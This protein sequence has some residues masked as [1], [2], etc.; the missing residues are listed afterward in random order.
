LKGQEAIAEELGHAFDTSGYRGFLKTYARIVEAE[1]YYYREARAYAMLREKDAAFAALEKALNTRTGFRN[2]KV[3]PR[4][5]SLRSD[6]R[7]T[8]ILRRTGLPQ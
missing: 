1:G 6:P 8:D 7:F 4:L 5:D 2:I 3:D